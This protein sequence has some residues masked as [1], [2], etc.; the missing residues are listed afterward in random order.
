MSTHPKNTAN[1]NTF[2]L[3][4]S[5]ATLRTDT[6]ERVTL[7]AMEG[8]LFEVYTLSTRFFARSPDRRMSELHQRDK[9]C[10]LPTRFRLSLRVLMQ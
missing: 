9:R 1:A 10:K 6:P 7:A 8:P 4:I 5:A 2:E 3:A